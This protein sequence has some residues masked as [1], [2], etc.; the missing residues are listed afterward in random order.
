M[1]C[2]RR[3]K[4][5]ANYYFVIWHARLFHLS[6]LSVML[7]IFSSTEIAFTSPPRGYMAILDDGTGLHCEQTYR[8]KLQPLSELVESYTCAVLDDQLIEATSMKISECWWGMLP[9]LLLVRCRS[10][11]QIH[12]SRSLCEREA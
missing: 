8:F 2:R 1:T 10:H 6:L 9:V 11:H 7:A 5:P 12:S 3:R 4:G